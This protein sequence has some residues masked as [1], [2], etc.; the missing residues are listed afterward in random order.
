[1][2]VLCA[3]CARGGSKG[4]KNK[5]IKKLIGIPL[6]AH[7]IFQAKKSRIF[8]K[9]VVST[10]SKKIQNISKKFGAENWFIRPRHLSS[11]KSEKQLAI[12][13]L[14][15]SAEKYYKI[16]F[17]VIIDLDVTSPLRNIN[18]IKLAIKKQK[19]PF[20]LFN[21]GFGSSIKI[22]DLVKK[23]IKAYSQNGS[24]C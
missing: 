13:H 21:V 10:D 15:V 16:K 18:D 9:I 14:L 8:T 19:T 2:K 3:I 17:D 6:I 11:D 7:T 12:R 23:I 1:M 24:S 4:V 20:G 5:N 22:S